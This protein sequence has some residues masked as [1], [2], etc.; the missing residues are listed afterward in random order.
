MASTFGVDAEYGVSGERR[1]EAGKG[2]GELSG[3]GPG[4]IEA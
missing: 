3:P 2:E 1:T 4:A